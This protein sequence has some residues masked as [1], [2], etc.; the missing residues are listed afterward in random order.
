MFMTLLHSYKPREIERTSF[1]AHA[2]RSPAVA[3]RVVTPRRSWR[4]TTLAGA[5]QALQDG[6]G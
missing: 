6:V 2:L 5:G 4:R 3:L 1:G